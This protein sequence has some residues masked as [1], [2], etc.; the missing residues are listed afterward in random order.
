[1]NLPFFS[2]LKFQIALALSFLVFAMAGSMLVSQYLFEEIYQAEKIFQ[3]GG[4]LQ[5]SSHQMSMQ[6][7]NYLANEP[8]DSSAYHRDLNLYYKDLK[9]HIETFD[10]IENAFMSKQFSEEMTGM[11]VRTTILGHTQRGGK[12][13]SWDRVLGTRYGVCAVD[14]VAQEKWGHMAALRGFD[15]AAVPL[16]ESLGENKTLPLDVYDVAKNFFG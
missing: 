12:P 16:E 9:Y 10:M 8:E 3:L 4:K 15:V 7:M 5:K 2:T 11:D 13:T 14:M 1:M 6:A